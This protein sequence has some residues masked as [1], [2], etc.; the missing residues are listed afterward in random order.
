[1]LPNIFLNLVLHYNTCFSRILT[2]GFVQ[3]NEEGH[4]KWL[5]YPL[6]GISMTVTES[7]RNERLGWFNSHWKVYVRLRCL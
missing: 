3:R 7:D 2:L 6:R 5:F 1:M 4:E